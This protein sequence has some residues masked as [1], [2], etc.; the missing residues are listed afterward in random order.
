MPY[1]KE[2]SSE[3]EGFLRGD[4]LTQISDVK[5]AEKTFLHPYV[6]DV[7]TDAHKNEAD[8]RLLYHI[9]RKRESRYEELHVSGITLHGHDDELHK[10]ADGI[11]KCTDTESLKAILNKLLLNKSD[12]SPLHLEHVKK[13]EEYYNSEYLVDEALG[14][15]GLIGP[16]EEYFQPVDDKTDDKY[17]DGY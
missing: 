6:D 3:K 2:E 7:E 5:T 14:E 17:C 12:V 11:E 13:Y 1:S 15:D 8:A 9:A 4:M 16:N 10:E